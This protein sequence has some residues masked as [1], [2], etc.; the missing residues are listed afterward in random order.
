MGL[1][2]KEE[3]VKKA[4]KDGITLGCISVRLL[5]AQISIKSNFVTFVV[6]YAPT[7][8]APEGQKA[9]YMAALNCTVA[10]VPAREYVFVLTDANARTGKRG[11]GGGEADNKVLGAYGRDK[12]N[13]NGKPLLG[14]A[15]DNK[16][17]LLNTFF[18][19]PKSGVSYMFQSAS[20][21]K[22]QARLDYI[23]TKQADRRLIRCVNVRRPPREAPES[24]HNLVYAKVRIPR[25]SA[26]NQRKRNRTKETPNLADLRRLLTDPNLRFQVA[27]AMVDA[28]PPIPDGICISDIATDMADVILSTAADL[29][30]RS[31]RPHGARV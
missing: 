29:V 11:E 5:K 3:I 22:G 9:K 12:L 6:A 20:R 2:I 1:A 8:E 7:E 25:R 30:P 21:S 23:P 14:F 16:L 10:T 15:E 19:T 13:E 4:G 18:C 17:A 24:D 27:N 31:K 28:L 26:P